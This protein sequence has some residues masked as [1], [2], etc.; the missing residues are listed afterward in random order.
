MGSNPIGDAIKI[1]N[2]LNSEA[3][4]SALK[5]VLRLNKSIRK[6]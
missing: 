4:D 3:R 1:P 6:S 2:L 5:S